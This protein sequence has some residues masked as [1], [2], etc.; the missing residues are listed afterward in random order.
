ME[1]WTEYENNKSLFT[2]R[3][4]ALKNIRPKAWAWMWR[5]FVKGEAR[6]TQEGEETGSVVWAIPEKG[7]GWDQELKMGGK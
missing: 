6:L 5:M 4:A 2:E 1:T 3:Q 7:P